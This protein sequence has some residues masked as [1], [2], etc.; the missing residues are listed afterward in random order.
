[1]DGMIYTNVLYFLFL[2]KGLCRIEG[3]IR[4]CRIGGWLILDG[5]RAGGKAAEVGGLRNRRRRGE[6]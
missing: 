4:G 5:Q 3:E 6:S 2:R 1:M